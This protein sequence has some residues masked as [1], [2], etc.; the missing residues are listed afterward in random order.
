MREYESN[1]R[2]LDEELYKPALKSKNSLP[3]KVP[4]RKVTRNSPYTG[5]NMTSNNFT[6]VRSTDINLSSGNRPS[7]KTP[8]N[9]HQNSDQQVLGFDSAYEDHRSSS[10]F[11]RKAAGARHYESE[12]ITPDKL[13]RS[14]PYFGSKGFN[15]ELKP[16]RDYETLGNRYTRAENMQ[17]ALERTE[18][19]ESVSSWRN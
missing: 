19:T 1:Q 8:A 5:L 7:G 4:H 6:D 10:I 15:T 13:P 14:N 9:P 12:S 16:S 11:S 17:H 2:T 18:S 3:A